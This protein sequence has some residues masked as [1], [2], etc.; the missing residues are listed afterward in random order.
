M[1]VINLTKERSK[2]AIKR[3]YK[4]LCA[5]LR[6]D[7]NDFKSDQCFC[8]NAHAILQQPIAFCRWANIEL[9]PVKHGS[10]DAIRFPHG[11][12]PSR[13]NRSTRITRSTG[14][15][16]TQV[17]PYFRF[18]D[19]FH[20]ASKNNRGSSRLAF[21]VFNHKHRKRGPQRDYAG[22]CWLRLPLDVDRT[23]FCTV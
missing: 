22:L 3:P 20:I 1:A 16:L 7:R 17:S 2:T 12:S 15:S 21:T 8:S 19:F 9:N 6:N 11:A 4:A 14:S 23:D 13:L 5:S 10:K 18:S